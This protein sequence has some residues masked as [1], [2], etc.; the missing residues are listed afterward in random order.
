M[1]GSIKS[2]KKKRNKDA[3]MQYTVIVGVFVQQQEDL[4]ICV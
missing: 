1:Y 2:K 3:G 4:L